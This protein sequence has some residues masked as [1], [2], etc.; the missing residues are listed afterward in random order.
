MRS[1]FVSDVGNRAEPVQTQ[2]RKQIKNH[3]MR[4]RFFQMLETEWSPC[5]LSLENKLKII[6]CNIYIQ[7]K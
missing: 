2:L 1:G 5:R 4:S 3:Q 7:P 6:R